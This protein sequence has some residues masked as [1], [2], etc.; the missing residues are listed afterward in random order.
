MKRSPILFVFVF[1]L[2]GIF[3]TLSCTSIGLNPTDLPIGV[4]N[5]EANCSEASTADRCEAAAL[6][7]YYLAALDRTS[8]VKLVPMTDRAAMEGMARR[9][10]LRGHLTVPRHFTHSFLHR[11]LTAEQYQDWL[12]YWDVEDTFMDRQVEQ[13]HLA[14]D[15]SNPGVALVLRE[16]VFQSLDSFF[17]LINQQCGRE[18]EGGTLD[19]MVVEEDAPSLGREGTTFQQWIVPALLALSFFFQVGL[20]HFTMSQAMCL[21]SEAFITERAEVRLQV[22]K[23]PVHPRAS[24]SAPGW[25]EC[26]PWRLSSPS[27]CP[28]S[29]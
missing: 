16:A 28:S 20:C 3:M 12:Y 4:I 6:S 1:F 19:L 9:G 11:L 27:S 7:C 5:H 22:S 14:M 24:S 23:P 8:A 18:L 21:T 17:S 26:S 2:P 13:L 29:W 10:E 25:L 15:T